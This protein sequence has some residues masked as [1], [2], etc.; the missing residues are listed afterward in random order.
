MTTSTDAY[1]YGAADGAAAVIASGGTAPYSY[2]WSNG[3]DSSTET[4]LT[5][6]TDTVTVTD[7]NGCE[8]IESLTINEPTEIVYTVETTDASCGANDGTASVTVSGGT[9]DYEY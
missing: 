6:G 8:V 1:C 4:A 9:P 3:G 7:D 2:S 5:A